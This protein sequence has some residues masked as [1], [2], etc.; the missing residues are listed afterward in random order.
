MAQEWEVEDV[1]LP[2]ERKRRIFSEIP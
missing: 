2:K 1:V